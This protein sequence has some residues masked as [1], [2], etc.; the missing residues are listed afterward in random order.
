[1]NT[2][3][4]GFL[5]PKQQKFCDEYLTDL[6]ATRAALRAG[7]SVSTA[8][9]GQL[10]QLPKIRCYLQKRTGEASRKAQISHEMVLAELGKIA[11]A[12]MRN[13]YHSDGSLKGAQELTA[14]EAA[15]LWCI[16]VT[17]GQAGQSSFIRLNNK[18]SALEIGRAHV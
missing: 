17:D 9:N 8:L 18:L 6:N 1:M 10:M 11:F 15:A 4:T 5:T 16:R 14:D 13:Y 12:N 2:E 3:Q 7:Y